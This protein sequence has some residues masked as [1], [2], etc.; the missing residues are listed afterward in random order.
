MSAS[1]D[2]DKSELFRLLKDPGFL[3]NGEIYFIVGQREQFLS[4]RKARHPFSRRGLFD[5]SCHPGY[6][7]E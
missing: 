4:G 7:Q 3:S 1:I 5:G 2:Q 6:D